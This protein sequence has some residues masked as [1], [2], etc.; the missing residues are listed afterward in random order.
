[1]IQM[2][3]I[4]HNLVLFDPCVQKNLA[5]DEFELRISGVRSDRPANC[6]TATALIKSFLS[7]LLWGTDS[8]TWRWSN[9]IRL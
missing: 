2:T 1:M 9:G 7:M 3:E 4:I 6:A 8:W 5:D